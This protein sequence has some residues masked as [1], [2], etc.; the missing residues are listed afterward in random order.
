P[1]ARAPHH[2]RRRAALRAFRPAG[3]NWKKWPPDRAP[4]RPADPIAQAQCPE[5]S[6][7]GKGS[8]VQSS[9]GEQRERHRVPDETRPSFVAVRDT[10][11]KGGGRLEASSEA[12]GEGNQQG[13]APGDPNPDEPLIPERPSQNPEAGADVQQVS[14]VCPGDSPT[15]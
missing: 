1:R 12:G 13:R 6:R 10:V 8:M 11:L 9:G 3:G 4:P 15:A 2:P 7:G 5:R 14:D